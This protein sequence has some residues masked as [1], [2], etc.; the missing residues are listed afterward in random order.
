MCWNCLYIPKLQRCSRWSLEKEWSFHPTLHWPRDYSSLPGLVKRF[1]GPCLTTATWCCRKN[2]SQYEC[3]FHWKLCC[4]WLE[5]LRQRQIA[6]V[7]QGPDDNKN[8]YVNYMH[9]IKELVW[10]WSTTSL[11]ICVPDLTES[12]M[13]NALPNKERQRENEQ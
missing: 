9:D 10:S 6:V 11:L 4:H 8:W 7:S 1:P 12:F 5:F 2:F 3:S 13:Y